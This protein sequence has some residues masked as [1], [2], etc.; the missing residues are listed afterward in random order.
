MCL[1]GERVGHNVEIMKDPIV[2]QLAAKNKVRA[3]QMN[4]HFV[5][6]SASNFCL[7][8][9]VLQVFII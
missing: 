7:V 1:M 8:S 2:L 3:S 4:I 9:L 6:I 5:Q